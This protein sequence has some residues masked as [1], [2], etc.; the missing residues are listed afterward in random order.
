MAIESGF[1]LAQVLRHWDSP[2][3]GGAFQFFQDLRKPRTDRITQTSYET[4]KMASCEIPED[5]W[6]EVFNY[7]VMRE[8]MRWVMEYDLFSDIF[9]KGGGLFKDNTGKIYGDSAA[10]QEKIAA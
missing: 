8:R 1:A 6:A 7:S 10:V 3:L 2:D 9:T 4:G 5:K